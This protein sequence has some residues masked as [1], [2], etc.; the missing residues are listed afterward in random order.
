MLIGDDVVMV[1]C[2]VCGGSG[3]VYRSG[4]SGS[5][6][7]IADVTGQADVANILG[8]ECEQCRRYDSID[9]EWLG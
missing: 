7:V 8:C 9:A 3:G 6:G 1:G 4:V 2:D 5:G